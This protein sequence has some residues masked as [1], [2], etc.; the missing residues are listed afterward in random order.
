MQTIASSRLTLALVGIAIV[1]AVGLTAGV[2][3]L[4]HASTVSVIANS[5]QL[6]GISVCGHGKATTRPDQARIDVG[7]S[8][9]A[10]TAEAARAQAAQSMSAVLAALKSN[11]VA[12]QDIQTDYFAIEPE[13]SYDGGSPHQIGYIAT[14]SVTATIR[15]VDNVGKVVDAVT[16]AG[17]NNVVVSGIQFSAGD[18]TQAEAQAE[19]NALADAHR[20]AEQIAEGAGVG[21]GAPLSIQVG[22]CG[23]TERSPY[24]VTAN[25]AAAVGTP[26]TP[27]QPGQQDVT[28]DVA[29]VYAIH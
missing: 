23:Q 6:T 25:G 29:V 16:Q 19:Q 15:A 7:V 18:P 21:L 27:I 13:Y 26:S 28:V 1:V 24:P 9:S 17:G 12:D 2:V 4:A 3:G 22:G 11:G 8:A 10:P 5:T 14:N 20:Q